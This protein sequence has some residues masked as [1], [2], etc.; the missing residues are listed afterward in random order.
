MLLI[1]LLAQG[2]DVSVAL[3]LRT[4]EDGL[5]F[6]YIASPQVGRAPIAD[7][8]RT[9][10]T[11]LA[12][13]KNVSIAIS[14]IKLI[15]PDNPIAIDA[16]AFRERSSAGV[17]SKYTG[18]RLG[19]LEVEEAYIYPRITPGLNRTQVLQAVTQLMNRKGVIQPSLFT[20]RNGS[21]LNAIPTGVRVQQP[22]GIMVEL[23]NVSS[24][25]NDSFP[26][27]EITNIQ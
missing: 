24:G 2:F 5:W 10:Y 13:L 9:A 8:Y 6:L 16:M 4:H 21:S 26:I 25:V 3:W 20:F 7:A 18:T 12:R 23:H 1:Q 22:D 19:Q 27:E 14:N 15:S 17:P 11:A